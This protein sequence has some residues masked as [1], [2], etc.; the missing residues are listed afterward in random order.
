MPKFAAALIAAM[1]LAGTSHPA[2][3]QSDPTME[4]MRCLNAIRAMRSGESDPAIVNNLESL[5]IFFMG[6][7][8]GQNGSID[9]ESLTAFAASY[10]TERDEA[11]AAVT[12]FKAKP[13]TVVVDNL[14]SSIEPGLRQCFA[15]MDQASSLVAGG[16]K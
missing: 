5:E 7:L 9:A 14:E 2:A 6:R 8:I 12:A 1:V 11:A 4:A 13:D 10:Q 16:G 15:A 3:A